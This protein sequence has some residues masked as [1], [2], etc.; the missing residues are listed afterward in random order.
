[1]ELRDQNRGLNGPWLNLTLVSNG[2][3]SVPLFIV[4]VVSGISVIF[5]GFTHPDFIEIIY[6]LNSH[7]FRA[8]S[9]ADYMFFS[10]FSSFC[11]L[12]TTVLPLVPKY[13]PGRAMTATSFSTYDHNL[14]PFCLY[15]Y[16]LPWL[17]AMCDCGLKLHSNKTF[18]ESSNR[19]SI[20]PPWLNPNHKLMIHGITVSK[21]TH[22]VT[23]KSS[24]PFDSNCSSK[25]FHSYV[26]SPPFQQ[27]IMVQS[28]FAGILTSLNKWSCHNCLQCVIT[29]W[30]PLAGAYMSIA[31]MF[32]L[33]P[34]NIISY[35]KVAARWPF[36]AGCEISFKHSISIS[37]WLFDSKSS[38]I[39]H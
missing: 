12:M 16:V 27:V 28:S 29:V 3:A 7:S 39:I 20:M 1:M 34:N 9:H 21:C 13:C 14:A 11:W 15:S 26:M 18:D 2:F 19:R 33:A 37:I 23:C 22:M 35:S 4:H 8:S 30:S 17:F 31:T 25:H 24:S 10:F 38:G 5:Q 36:A 6:L 32:A